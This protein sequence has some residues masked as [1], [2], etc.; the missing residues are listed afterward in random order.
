MQGCAS[1]TQP[2]APAINVPTNLRVN[3]PIVAQVHAEG[4]QVYTLKRDSGGNP[5]WVLKAPD[6]TFE[7]AKGLKGKHYA[8]PTWECTTD[9][10]KVVGRKIADH[11][12]PNADAVPWLLLKA[13]GHEGTGFFS[14]VT[15]IQ[16]ENT[17]GG[18]APAI[19][20]GKAGD[21]VR[22]PYEADY[23][24]YGAIATTQTSLP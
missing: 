6:A 4:F 13:T 22:V 21:E 23:V 12:S 9:G 3:G 14:T 19:D 11:P 2:A 1:H 7:N 15:F 5:G 8:G 24:F 20:D 16:R 10:S 17:V 18:K